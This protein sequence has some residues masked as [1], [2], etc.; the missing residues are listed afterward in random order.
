MGPIPVQLIFFNMAVVQT[1]FW[2]FIMLH[3]IANVNCED[4][5]YSH[6]NYTSVPKDIP[7]NAT[8]IKLNDN[9]I[10]AIR[11]ADFNNFTNLSAMYLGRNWIS[12]IDRGCFKGTKLQTIVLTFSKLTVFPDFSQVAATLEVINLK[13]NKIRSVL[14]DDV[15]D[16][17][18]LETLYLGNNPLVF[19]TDQFALLFNLAG[20]Y[21]KGPLYF[22]ATAQLG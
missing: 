7:R 3:S 11:Q 22:A 15:R 14:P 1:F 21:L 20:L 13:G 12:H 8:K 16:L 6:G 10:T 17:K 19:I 9:Q 4:Y 2:T 5:N 18:K